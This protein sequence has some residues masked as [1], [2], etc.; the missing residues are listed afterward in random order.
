[1]LG[2]ERLCPE[3]G[4]HDERLGFS[5]FMHTDPAR[6]VMITMAIPIE[7]EQ[8]LFQERKRIAEE[9]HDYVSQHL[10]G[11]VYA[12]HSMKRDW[13]GM[14]EERK[15][16]Q[17]QEIQEA[18]AAASRELRAAIYNLHSCQSCSASWIGTI[19]SHLANQAKL[20]GVR[21]RFH[22]PESDS[23]FSVNQQNAL[24]RI[25]S[26]GVGNAIRH[27]ASSIV[28][29]RLIIQ[30][31]AVNLRIVDNGTGFEMRSR[32]SNKTDSGFG[33][34]NMLALASSLGG[35]LEIDSREGCGTRIL[36]W[37]PLADFHD[38]T[39]QNTKSG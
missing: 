14:T 33:I 37:L 32:K 6:K 2:V 4:E 19:Q 23:G 27:G 39:S 34:S 31:G 21:I 15:L 16:E 12:V 11:I 18:A 20:N 25:I 5:H 9:L 3:V 35:T 26:E 38:G 30:H 28:D 22:A 10:F 17:M 36:V 29:V 24:Y 8:L 13:K 1:M 7:S